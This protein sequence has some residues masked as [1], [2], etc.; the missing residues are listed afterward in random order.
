MRT[1]RVLAVVVLAYI[2]ADFVDAMDPGIFCFDAEQ[3]F[4]DSVV[5]IAP[6][7]I[8]ET[9]RL[10]P[11][12]VDWLARMDSQQRHHVA[13]IQAPRVRHAPRSHI[14]YAVSSSPPSSS[15]DH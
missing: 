8:G 6:E 10:V 9:P 3:L 12:R 14:A 5:Q 13:R 15:E 11:A 1:M 7:R 4:V 2:T